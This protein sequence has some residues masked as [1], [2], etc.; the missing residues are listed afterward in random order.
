VSASNPNVT[1]RSQSVP[2]SQRLCLSGDA[3]PDIV[4]QLTVR[5]PELLW[6]FA[7]DWAGLAEQRF[8]KHYTVR[9]AGFNLFSFPSNAQLLWFDMSRFVDRI[10]K[11]YGKT[12]QAVVSHEEQ[13]GALAAALVAERLGL[14][15]TNPDAILKLQHKH[16]C[17][18]I[19]QKVAPECNLGFEL[20]DC[21][22]GDLPDVELPYPVFIKPIKASFSILA[23]Q[24]RSKA[25]L[26]KH[27]KFGSFEQHIIRRLVKPFDDICQQRLGGVTSARNMLI[28]ENVRAEQFNL[29]GYVFDGQTHLLGVIDEIMYP[30]T[31]AFLRFSYPSALPDTV[32]QRAFDVAKKVLAEAGFDHGFFNME[33]FYDRETNKLQIVEFNPRLAAQLADMYERVDG[34]DVHAMSVALAFGNDPAAVPRNPSNGSVAA[35]CALRTFDGKMP[36]PVSK[37]QRLAVEQAYDD[38]IVV[39]FDKSKNGAR[40]EYKWLDSNR[41]GVINLHGDNP[42]HLRARYQEICDS[43][44]W[45]APF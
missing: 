17:R 2:L 45:A 16:I 19:I 31:Q 15:G 11:K 37:G 44:G 29:D 3:L 22:L 38:A 30:D 5:P 43:L 4:N 42:A 35:S 10:E 28:E 27:L 33:F 25:E 26:H 24:L 39:Y 20:L 34:L 12:L 21:D 40:R 6:L 14:P 9:S 18:Q 1:E 7:Q 13:F 32:Q 8:G 36:P 23:R 41:Y